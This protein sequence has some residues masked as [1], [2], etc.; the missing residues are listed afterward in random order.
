LLTV[1]PLRVF[2]S[3]G[4]IHFGLNRNLIQY[5]GVAGSSPDDPTGMRWRMAIVLAAGPLASLLAGGAALAL[6]LTDATDTLLRD[7]YVEYVAARCIALFAAGSLAVGLI[8]AM[9]G[10]SRGR[11]TDGSRILELLGSGPRAD[12][13]AAILSLNS[14]AL[15]GRPP[16][17]WPAQLIERALEPADGSPAELRALLLAHDAAVARGRLEHARTLIERALRIKDAPPPLRTAAQRAAR[18]HRTNPET[19]RTGTPN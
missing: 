9:P 11:P 19:P 10:G 16:E 17:D 13:A 5:A 1:G 18:H 6:L 7:R 15:A 3:N 4:R 12:R 14:L 8:T 2:R